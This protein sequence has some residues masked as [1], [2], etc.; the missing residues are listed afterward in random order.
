MDRN[1]VKSISI[2]LVLLIL[3]SPLSGFAMQDGH[4]SQSSQSD[5]CDSQGDSLSLAQEPVESTQ[6]ITESCAETCNIS[7]AC[8][9]PPHI[10]LAMCNLQFPYSGR[11]YTLDL[12]SDSHLFIHPSGLYRPPRA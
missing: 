11:D 6:C 9:S 2:L 1:Q 3:L 8:S 4:S 12:I 5:H 10:V 7:R